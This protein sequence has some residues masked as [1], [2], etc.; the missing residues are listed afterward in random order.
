M[1]TGG[2]ARADIPAAHSRMTDVPESDVPVPPDG[3]G[4]RAGRNVPGAGNA[5][6]G[7]TL[8]ARGVIHADW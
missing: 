2:A 6:G 3:W 7:P 4:R 8:T 1:T 5:R